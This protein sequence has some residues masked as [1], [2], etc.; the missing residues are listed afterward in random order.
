MKSPRKLRRLVSRL[1]AESGGA[2]TGPGSDFFATIQEHWTSKLFSARFMAFT[3]SAGCDGLARSDNIH[4]EILAIHAKNPGTGQLREFIKQAKARFAT[5]TV[6][7]IMNQRL[8]EALTRYG[9]RVVFV[10]NLEPRPVRA[11][12]WGLPVDGK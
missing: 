11:M 3:H 9:F 4:L 1:R 10:Q 8:E 5:I 7:E 2:Y 6:F 12:R